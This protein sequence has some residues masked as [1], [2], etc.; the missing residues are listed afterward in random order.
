[1]PNLTPQ[2]SFGGTAGTTLN[3]YTATSLLSPYAAISGLAWTRHAVDAQDAQLD[4]TGG[5]R[6]TGVVTGGTYLLGAPPHRDYTVRCRVKRLSDLGLNQPDVIGVLARYDPTAYTGYTAFMTGGEGTLA[7]RRQVAGVTT[8]LVTTT[9]GRT[10]DLAV[11]ETATLELSVGG[12]AGA[13]AAAVALRFVTPRKTW[14][15]SYIDSSPILAAGQAGLLLWGAQAAGTGTHAREFWVSHPQAA[16][17]GTDVVI[18]FAGDSI[19]QSYALPGGQSLPEM[20]CARLRLVGGT[21]RE[22]AWINQGIGGSKSTEWASGQANY[23]TAAAVF[24]TVGAQYTSLMIGTNDAH[25]LVQTSLNNYQAALASFCA[26]EIAA[27]RKV[28]LHDPP[29]RHDADGNLTL[30]AGYQAR[31]AALVNGTTILRGDTQAYNLVRDNPGMLLDG[32]HLNREGQVALANLHA[33]A[34]RRAIQ[35]DRARTVT[36]FSGGFSG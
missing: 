16:P 22:V 23:T 30:L 8:T 1:M 15:L 29:Y 2:C 34:I 26:A 12:P 5:V 4:G 17:S 13:S 10:T 9:F 19:T 24:T 3:G 27:G 18:G 35:R 36:T 31:T 14:E 32:V 11:G 20:V 6:S 28:I 21:T 7:L 25:T 33:D